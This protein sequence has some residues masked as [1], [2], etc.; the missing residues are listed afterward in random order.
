MK[1]TKEIFGKIVAEYSGKPQFAVEFYILENKEFDV[2]SYGIQ[3][4][5]INFGET[6]AEKSEKSENVAETRLDVEKII[7]SWIDELF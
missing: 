3:I 7:Q 1:Q 2:T 4:D 5:K 6:F